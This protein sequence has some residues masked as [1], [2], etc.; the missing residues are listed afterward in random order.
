MGIGVTYEI[1][2]LFMEASELVISRQLQRVAGQIFSRSMFD[3]EEDADV[4]IL[5]CDEG[6]SSRLCP[7]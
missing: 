7:S 3:L 2:S 6:F 4:L 1:S 5:L